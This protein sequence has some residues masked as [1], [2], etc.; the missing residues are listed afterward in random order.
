MDR[1]I[2]AYGKPRG[3][4]R[5]PAVAALFPHGLPG[6]QRRAVIP[7]DPPSAARLEVTESLLVDLEA[8]FCRRARHWGPERNNLASRTRSLF[9]T[10]APNR[11]TMADSEHPYPGHL[12]MLDVLYCRVP[13]GRRRIER[14]FNLIYKLPDVSMA[15]FLNSM[16]HGSTGAH[17]TINNAD[18]V[19]LN[20]GVITGDS[21]SRPQQIM[22][23]RA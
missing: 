7:I 12:V 3:Y 23:H 13:G 20:D 6:T 15:A 21:S 17:I 8:R 19:I 4:P 10:G 16:H 18:L 1:A 2:A 9:F 11:K 5:Q 14:Q 22:L